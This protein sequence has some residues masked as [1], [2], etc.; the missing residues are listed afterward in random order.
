[1]RSTFQGLWSGARFDI[2]AQA[3]STAVFFGA[4][5]RLKSH[6]AD[7]HSPGEL[8]GLQALQAGSTAGK[9]FTRIY[10]LSGKPS[11]CSY[12]FEQFLF[13]FH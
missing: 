12:S 5:C 9:R 2:L 3:A 8:Q 7:P 13:F 6:L 10:P 4:Y 1:M 11:W